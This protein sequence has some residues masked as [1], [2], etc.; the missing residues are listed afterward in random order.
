MLKLLIPLFFLVITSCGNSTTNTTEKTSETIAIAPLYKSDVLEIIKIT[1]HIYVHT[2]YL[3]TVE[4]GNVP[5]NGMVVINNNEAVIFDSPTDTTGSKELIKFVSQKLNANT[6]GVIPT[7]FHADCIGGISAFEE[8]NIPVYLSRLTKELV[9]GDSLSI[10]EKSITFE[11]S[12]SV[13]VGGE[14][15]LAQ[16]F[17]E[18]HTKD[19]IIGYFPKEEAMFGGCLIKSIGSGKGNLEDANVEEWAQTARKIKLRYPE[20]EIVIPG[21]GKLGNSK[22]LDFTIELFSK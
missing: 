14:K 11:D 2:S 4:Y 18:G 15:V 20:V 9:S 13:N 21:H 17:G 3:K 19:N 8:R 12:L 16:Y 6:I 22:L 5:C 1:D 10:L 7:H